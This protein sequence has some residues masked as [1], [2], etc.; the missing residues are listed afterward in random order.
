MIDQNLIKILIGQIL[1]CVEGEHSPWLCEL[2]EASVG[3]GDPDSGSALG[4]LVAEKS[5]S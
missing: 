1:S 5:A 3:S 2:A 4:V